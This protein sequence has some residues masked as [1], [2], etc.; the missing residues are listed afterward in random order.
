MQ[1]MNRSTAAL[2]VTLGITVALVAGT[3]CRR[4]ER[5][6]T[7][8]SGSSA[9]EADKGRSQPPKRSH[10]RP[11]PRLRLG[12]APAAPAPAAPAKT[13]PRAKPSLVKPSLVKP[14]LVKPTLVKPD[15]PTP[16]VLVK[17][18]ATPRLTLRYRFHSDDKLVW[19]TTMN[20][21]THVR[22]EK[23]CPTDPKTKLRG[24]TV[25]TI[26]MRYGVDLITTVTQAPDDLYQLDTRMAKV[27]MSLPSAL[28]SHRQLMLKVLSGLRY[29][30]RMSRRGLVT[31][32]AFG[33]MTPKSL[34][35]LSKRLKAPLNHLQP[36]LPAAPV[37]VGA[38][39][40]H[41]REHPLTQPGGR[42]NAIYLT[43]YQLTAIRDQD[44]V[45]VA[46][47]QMTTRVKMT[48][49]VMGVPFTGGGSGSAKLTLDAVRGVIRAAQGNLLICSA[50]KDR[51][52]TNRTVFTQT[53]QSDTP[54][55]PTSPKRP[56]PRPVDT[57]PNPKP[58]P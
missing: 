38:V 10:P 36:M 33:K 44:G 24:T 39:W 46:N 17:A 18:G 52:S 21:E 9:L 56:T 13:G 37:G 57:K 35:K 20:Q 12:A 50:V 4:V 16:F 34:V 42:I 27:T 25:R 41:R 58:K 1:P 30:R 23:R 28:A 8:G 54:A 5:S 43:Q 2:R 32:F 14:T 55:A 47:I 48:G 3:N 6:G 45:Q 53:L 11:R 15:Q 7:E 29:T 22:N 19:R 26:P 49:K 51:T 31:R 40:R